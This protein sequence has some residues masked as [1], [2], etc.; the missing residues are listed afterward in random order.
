M[1]L[2]GGLIMASSPR[3][4]TLRG[5]AW[6]ADDGIEVIEAA[7]VEAA[8]D[9]ALRTTWLPDEDGG[10]GPENDTLF[11]DR[12]AALEALQPCWQ[13]WG[14]TAWGEA[15]KAAE[16]VERLRTALRHIS[17]LCQM[18]GGELAH[19]IWHEAEEAL[20][21]PAEADSQ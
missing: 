13:G 7:V 12:W 10:W 17:A 2:R 19:T 5:L 18:E 9:A 15:G 3:R 8:I 21:P 14:D 1:S 16:K 20:T 11:A 4:W 6:G